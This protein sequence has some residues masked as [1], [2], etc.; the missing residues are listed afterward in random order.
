MKTFLVKK[1]TKAPPPPPPLQ[2]NINNHHVDVDLIA[3]NHN[4]IG[5]VIFIHK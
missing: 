4:E 5:T 3:Q 1:K 2:L